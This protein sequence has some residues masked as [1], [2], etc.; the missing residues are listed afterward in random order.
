MVR[1]ISAHPLLEEI[2]QILED[3]AYKETNQNPTAYLEKTTKTKIRPSPIDEEIQKTNR[4]QRTQPVAEEATCYVK[5][6]KH[7]PN[8]KDIKPDI[9]ASLGVISL[10]PSIPIDEALDQIPMNEELPAHIIE[11]PDHYLKNTYLS[12]EH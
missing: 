11:L 3:D 7:F 2:N 4:K 8:N 9:C 1:N 6:S 10:H 5:N 12:F